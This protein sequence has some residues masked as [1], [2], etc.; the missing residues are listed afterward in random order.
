[1]MTEL[2]GTS[3]LIDCCRS[4]ESL[5]PFSAPCRRR[6]VEG[7]RREARGY[8]GRREATA[9]RVMGIDETLFAIFVFG[10]MPTAERRRAMDG[11]RGGKA[12]RN[13]SRPRSPS[14]HPKAIGAT[15]LDQEA[16]QG[17]LKEPVRHPSTC[18]EILERKA[19]D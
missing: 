14:R 15:P 16:L 12:N 8:G 3:S 9:G 1:M 18:S 4:A 2:E 17:T 5:F 11:W 6:N 10:A 7:L 13:G 19:L